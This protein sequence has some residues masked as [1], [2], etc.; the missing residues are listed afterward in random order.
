MD[1]TSE[2]LGRNDPCWCGSG[3]KY[4]RCHL[5]RH[6]QAPLQ[7]WNVAERFRKPFSLKKCLAPAAWLNRCC[8]RIV[9]A[10][11]LPK[12]GSLQ[13]IARNGH[14]Y[15]LSFVPTPERKANQDALVAKLRGINQA[16][17]FSGFC[18]RHDDAIFSPVESQVFQG[19]PEQCFLLGYRSLAKEIYNKRAA[20]GLSDL[21]RDVD[22]GKTLPA[23]VEIQRFN[24][25]QEDGLAAAL[26]DSN[27]YKSLYDEILKG[28]Q[29]KCVRG[30]V[31]EF[32]TPPSV[33]CSGGLY[34][35]QDF[36]GVELQ[37]VSDLSSTPD[38]LSFTSFYGGEC[39]VVVFCWLEKNDQTCGAFIRSLRVIADEF[40]T[41]ALLRL[42]FTHCENIYM[43]P[44]WWESLPEGTRNALVRRMTT[45]ANP[46]TGR[47]K[48]VLA[49]DGV[50]YA[51]WTILR[52]YQIE[53]S[54]CS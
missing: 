14:V 27:H 4:K 34:P 44:D 49:D 17:T 2:K 6:N 12:S 21:R 46:C 47:P 18:S 53:A 11:T 23:Q 1:A 26:Q 7:Y 22:K 41:A 37:D 24:Q 28:R 36:D 16:S 13:R 51:P 54:G 38:L 9:R 8:G 32:E 45:S 25:G 10:H 20:V 5:N 19:T 48:A 35:E 40:V 42:F 52:R 15:S 30:Y 29:F 43:E 3:K 50:D 39:G 31:I 33:M